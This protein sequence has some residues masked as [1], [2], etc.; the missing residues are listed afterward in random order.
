M[1]GTITVPEVAHDTEDDE[2]VVCP[3]LH[4]STSPN[5]AAHSQTVRH[6]DVLRVILQVSRQGSREI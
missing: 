3:S 5:V 4:P 6:R 2:Y 1:S